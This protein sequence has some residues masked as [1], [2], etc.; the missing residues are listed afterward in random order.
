MLVREILVKAPKNRNADIVRN[1]YKYQ[2]NCKHNTLPLLF[3]ICRMM[4]F[5]QLD[6]FTHS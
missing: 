3:E 4:N 6:N 1:L 5:A 2:I